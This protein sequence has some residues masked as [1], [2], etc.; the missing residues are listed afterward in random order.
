MHMNRWIIGLV[1][2]LPAL[3]ACGS[4][5]GSS[6]TGGSGGGSSTTSTST[7]SSSGSTS[8][9][10][11]GG[12]GTGGAGTGGAGTGGAGAGGG[13]GLMGPYAIAY[14]GTFV[15][16]DGRRPNSATFTGSALDGYVASADEQPLIGTAQALDVFT[17]SLVLAGR[18]AGG[19]TAGTFY[20]KT[21]TFPQDGGFQY[22][23]GS[24][25][26][27]LPGSGAPAYSLIHASPTTV[28]DGSL[29]PGSSNGAIGVAF[30]G[31]ATKVGASFQLVLPGDQ[32]YE[33]TTT[34]GTSNPAASEIVVF[35]TGPALM[36]GTTHPSS[37][38]GACQGTIPCTASI[39]GFFAGP[40]AE[41]AAFAVHVYTGSGGA[42]K[43][44]SATFVFAKN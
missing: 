23:I 31:D 8:S 22:V 16:V 24:R 29:A 2:T 1:S 6:G 9:T 27:T 14:A 26:P 42:P 30:A 36:G 18:W 4:G 17:D 35:P 20:G 5:G 19:T 21:F 38:T 43:T 32:T 7:S 3:A 39:F 15:G 34:G 13:A 33:V 11:T 12:A 10:G 44:V 41:R 37:T 25:T 40:A 28:S